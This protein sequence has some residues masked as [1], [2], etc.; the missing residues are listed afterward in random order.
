LRKPVRL[1]PLQGKGG[2]RTGAATKSN[3]CAVELDLCGEKYVREKLQANGN[4]KRRGARR[5][6]GRII[7]LLENGRKGE[8]GVRTKV[9]ELG[10]G[11]EKREHFGIGCRLWNFAKGGKGFF[12]G[13]AH[14]SREV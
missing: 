3:D 1:H 7:K 6:E 13:T 2:V 9:H 4:F 8:G 5:E 10:E 14:A 11:R 12:Q